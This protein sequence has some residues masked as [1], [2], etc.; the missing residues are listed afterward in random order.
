MATEYAYSPLPSGADDI[1]LLTLQP[2]NKADNL[3]IIIQHCSLV[4]A[5]GQYDALSYVW[6][7]TDNPVT[8]TVRSAL[9][10]EDSSLSVTQN[11]AVAL[12]HLCSSNTPRTL[13]IDAIC[14]DQKNMQERS[15][16]VLRMND[17]YRMATRVVSE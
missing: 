3:E 16:Q 17:I 1:R 7:S 9:L 11:L 15:E 4:T 12:K 13:W 5:A 10:T 6:G 14:I 2:G 8:I